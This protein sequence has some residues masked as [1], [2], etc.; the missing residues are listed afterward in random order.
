[1][2]NGADPSRYPAA[3]MTKTVLVPT[4]LISG[5]AAIWP[6]GPVRNI[7]PNAAGST[8]LRRTAGV[9]VVMTVKIGAPVSGPK[10]PCRTSTAATPTA[11]RGNPSSS[12]GIDARTS[13]PA[14]T[15]SAEPTH[16]ARDRRHPEQCS[17]THR[18][19][20]DT[21][22]AGVL[23]VVGIREYGQRRQEQREEELHRQHRDAQD[24]EQPGSEDVPDT[25]EQP[26]LLGFDRR[27]CP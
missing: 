24:D 12:F 18:R 4:A 2:A 17:G 6:N 26:A 8:R 11:G 22:D 1:M 23:V 27:F 15:W 21:G 3:A 5:P 16:D 10:N 19:V 9:R 20:E 25:R 7:S 14:A 13:A